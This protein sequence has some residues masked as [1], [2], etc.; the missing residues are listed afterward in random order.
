MYEVLI[1]LTFVHAMT[2]SL[3]STTTTG[4]TYSH[5][6]TGY[7][8]NWV[9]L[10]EGGYPKRLGPNDALYDSDPIQECLKRCLAVY[11]EAGARTSKVGGKIGNQAFYL[12]S[13]SLCACAIGECKSLYSSGMEAESYMIISGN[14]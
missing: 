12:N 8:S 14:L 11:G 9:Y 1:F 6:G 13:D 5:I 2:F 4:Y 3:V 10:P 7:C